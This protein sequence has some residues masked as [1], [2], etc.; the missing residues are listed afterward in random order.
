MGQISLIRLEKLETAMKLE[1]NLLYDFE[2]WAGLKLHCFNYLFM[3]KMLMSK[4]FLF[5]YFW[6]KSKLNKNFTNFKYLKNEKL[7]INV[8]N[9]IL[10]T[11]TRVTLLNN[12]IYQRNNRYVALLVYANKTNMNR[13]L[14]YLKKVM[15]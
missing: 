9:N 15:W 12:Y 11:K 8:Q 13:T 10:I 1:S 4:P 6:V 14:Y 2:R 3:R 5:K 7:K